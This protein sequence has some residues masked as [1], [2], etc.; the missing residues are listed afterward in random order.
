M[1]AQGAGTLAPKFFIEKIN[2]PE[3]KNKVFIFWGVEVSIE[4]GV[5]IWV[6]SVTN[7]VSSLH[8]PFLKVSIP[9]HG[10]LQL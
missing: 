9:E 10:S 4:P 5:S 8:S 3:R 7:K 6:C 1:G 2:C